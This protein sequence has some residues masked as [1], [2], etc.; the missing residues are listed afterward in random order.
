M[1]WKTHETKLYSTYRNLS[2]HLRS[3]YSSVCGPW[4]HLEPL[5]E[6]LEMVY[7]GLH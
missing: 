5:C 1:K 6:Q 7:Q 4:R 3:L 2:A